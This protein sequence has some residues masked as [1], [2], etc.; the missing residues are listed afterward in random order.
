[1]D[2]NDT[3]S[4]HVKIQSCPQSLRYPSPVERK[5]FS[6]FPVLLDKGNKG[7]GDEIG[8]DSENMDH[9]TDIKFVS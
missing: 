5:T 9:F 4:L 2:K 7:S 3:I 6:R 1:M 8:E